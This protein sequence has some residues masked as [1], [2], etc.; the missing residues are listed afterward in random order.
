[1]YAPGYLP[2]H[3]QIGE[4][5][6][7][8]TTSRKQFRK[9]SLVAQVYSMRG[10]TAQATQL[11]RRIMQL[12]PMDLAV[13]SRLIEALM[14]QGKVDDAIREQIDLAET[15]YHLTELDMART[16]YMTVLR[17]AQQSSSNR[18]WSTRILTRVA[19]IDM[20]RMD[21]RQAL[22]IFE[23]IRVLQPDDEKVRQKSDSTSIFRIGQ[24][25]GW[26]YRAGQL[27]QFPGRERPA[28]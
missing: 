27:Y 22:R 19:D 13:R 16:T 26:P 18:K 7:N 12:N 15:Y 8:E 4:L 5:L 11:L 24:E 28:R 3:V 20:Q 10:E 1:M 2:I 6:L 25:N 14:A 17:L 21:W 9:F 23:Q